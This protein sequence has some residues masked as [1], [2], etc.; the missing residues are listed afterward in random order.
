MSL[1][2]A[3]TTS[4]PR[5]G[6]AIGDEAGPFAQMCS[7]VER[8]H[9][10]TLVPAIDHLAQRAGVCLAEVTRLAVD[11]GP[12]LFT[13]LRV[14]LATAKALSHAL[15]A[16]MVAVSSLDLLAASFGEQAGCAVAAVIDARR[17][18]VFWRLYD[19][20]AATT[21]EPPPLPVGLDEPRAS[22]PDEL[23]AMLGSKRRRVIA[24][25]DGARRYCSV[26]EAAGVD[27]ADSSH[28]YP[29]PAVLLSLAWVL[30]ATGTDGVK[31]LY[32]RPPDVRVGWEKRDG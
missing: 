27:V 9:C 20:L 19:Q 8:R 7:N 21:A 31:P 29:P 26:L 15:G 22:S 18:E 11:I 3:I 23:A 10:E 13:G 16:S 12:G 24:T 25:G 28:D 17:G 14:G 2:I 1:A 6:L 32:V 30:P 5:I 4:T